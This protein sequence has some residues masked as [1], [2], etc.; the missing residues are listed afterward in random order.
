MSAGGARTPCTTSTTAVAAGYH[1][2][3]A[4]CEEDRDLSFGVIA[5]TMVT[6]DRLIGIL[7]RAQGIKAVT[8]FFTLIF[9]EWH[10]NSWIYKVK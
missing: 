7:D 6:N 8:A 10:R 4:L 9:V 1:A 5:L 2:S 3:A